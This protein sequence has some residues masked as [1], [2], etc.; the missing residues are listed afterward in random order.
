[1]NKNTNFENNRVYDQQYYLLEN[2]NKT[3]AT[4]EN[5]KSYASNEK[6]G[7]RQNFE[8]FNPSDSNNHSVSQKK[9]N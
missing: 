8:S 7:S 9:E 4:K 6:S 1:M 5:K 2:K 3:L